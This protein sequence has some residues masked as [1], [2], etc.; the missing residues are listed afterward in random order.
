MMKAD[1]VEADQELSER[2]Q[3]AGAEFADG[4]R[5]GAEGADRRCAHHDGDD[6]KEHPRGDLDQVGERLAGRAQG[7]EGEAAQHRDIE[8]LEHVAVAERA[9]E[10]VGDDVEEKLRGRAPLRL[11]DVRRDDPDGARQA[12]YSAEISF[13]V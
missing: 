5:H 9:D 6:A 4:E 11:F 12:S 8:Y 1:Q 7:A 3:R 10:G 13:P 2:E